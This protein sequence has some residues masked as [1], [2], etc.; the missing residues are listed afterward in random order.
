MYDP[1]MHTEIQ[2]PRLLPD[3][4]IIVDKSVILQHLNNSETDPFT[5]SKLTVETLEEYNKLTST[6]DEI[7][8]QYAKQTNR[9]NV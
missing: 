1:I 6:K 3:S 7:T 2:A 4:K 5:R 8:A 9:V